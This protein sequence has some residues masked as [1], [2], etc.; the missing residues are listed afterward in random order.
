MQHLVIWSDLEKV[1][2]PAAA[3]YVRAGHNDTAQPAENALGPTKRGASGCFASVS[4]V[5]H[6]LARLRAPAGVNVKKGQRSVWVEIGTR[7]RA[8]RVRFLRSPTALS[9]QQQRAISWG[10]APLLQDSRRIGHSGRSSP[11]HLSARSWTASLTVDIAA[12]LA[13]I[14]AM[15]QRQPFDVPA[16][17]SC[18]ARDRAA[19]GC[20]RSRSRGPGPV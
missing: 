15:V 10:S 16:G 19:G 5:A 18:P 2:H 11:S 3:S 8:L 1:D 7:D 6:G 12:I 4:L 13:A 17:G 20:D 9:Q 14:S